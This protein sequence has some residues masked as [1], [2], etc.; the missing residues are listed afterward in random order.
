MTKITILFSFF[1]I[2][3]FL[4]PLKNNSDQK[5]ISHREV[6]SMLQTQTCNSIL[7]NLIK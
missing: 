7:F 4:S 3:K 1:G 2:L 6:E 5:R